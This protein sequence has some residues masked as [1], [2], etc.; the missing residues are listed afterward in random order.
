MRLYQGTYKYLT[1]FKPL[2]SFWLEPEIKNQGSEQT[3]LRSSN[4]QIR[5]DL[6]GKELVQSAV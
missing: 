3:N 4:I 5:T 2:I 6:K 1:R